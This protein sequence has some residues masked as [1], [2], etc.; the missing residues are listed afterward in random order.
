MRWACAA[1]LLL[2]APLAAQEQGP[3]A[4]RLVLDSS[5]AL[6]AGNAARFLSY[7]DKRE[8]PGF[9]RL[10]ENALAL[11]ATKTVASSVEIVEVDVEGDQ[12]RLKVDWLLQ[13]TPQ[14]ELG[15]VERRREQ[16]KI[17]IRLGDRPKIVALE[18]VDLFRAGLSN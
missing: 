7:F 10:R 16:V 17:R 6:Q 3:A 4:R 8:T 15:A 5:R 13:L 12:A 2:A 14:R 9:A 11:L 1:L 18:P